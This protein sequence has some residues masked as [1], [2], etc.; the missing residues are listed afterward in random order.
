[1]VFKVLI[2][3]GNNADM[4]W[5]SGGRSLWDKYSYTKDKYGYLTFDI[6]KL[7]EFISKAEKI[8]GWHTPFNVNSP[9]PF[10]FQ[11]EEGNNIKMQ[12]IKDADQ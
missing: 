5:Y 11:D 2:D 8:R 4:W 10:I 3:Y 7:R 12:E 6:K 1:M 9:Y